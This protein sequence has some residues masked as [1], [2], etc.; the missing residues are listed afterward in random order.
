MLLSSTFWTGLAFV[1][2]VLFAYKP[3]G[4]LIAGGLDKRSESIRNELEEALRLKE[5]AQAVYASYQRKRQELLKE[6]EEIVAHAEKEAERLVNAAHKELEENVNNRIELAM[7][8]IAAYENAVLK[9]LQHHAV[10]N[11]IAKVEAMLEQNMTKKQSDALLDKS[12][13]SLE[14]QAV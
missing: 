3:V 2:F 5:E 6:A 8:K 11:T 7:K 4:R 1:A 9:E 14:K 12:I 10:D 13:A